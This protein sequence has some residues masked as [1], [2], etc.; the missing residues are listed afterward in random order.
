[1]PE[2]FVVI[3][4]GGRGE[5]FWP[6]SRLKKPKHLL[7][8]VGKQPML[9][10]TIA[11]VR[12]LVSR[13]NIIV[14]TT[15]S[16]LAAVRVACGRLPRRNIVVE[17]VGRDTAAAVGL[18]MLLVQTRSPDATFAVLPADHVIGD[19]AGFRRLLKAAFKAAESADELVTLGIEP[20]EPATGF[21]YIERGATWQ[22]TP[23]RILRAKRFVEKPSLAKARAYVSSGRYYWNAGMFV[24]RVPVI[25]AALARHAR[26]L[27][28][29]LQKLGRALVLGDSARALARIYPRLQKISIDFA[30]MEKARNVLVVPAN[31]GWDDVGSWPAIARHHEKDSAGNILRGMACVEAGR[32]NIVISSGRHLTAVLGLDNLVVVHTPE[33]TL[34]CHKDKTQEIKALLKRLAADPAKQKYL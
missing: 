12:P 34:V 29:G 25:A 9:T 14:I 21:G 18:A 5:R 1:M 11:R 8:I 27:H 6:Q 23:V 33:A 13:E 28:T 16:Q 24:W 3:M 19:V 31:F 2:R 20:T 22:D 26:E 10:Q 17:P 30:V 15:R 32:H 7:P 4:A